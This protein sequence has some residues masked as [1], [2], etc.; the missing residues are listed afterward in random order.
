[1]FLLAGLGNPGTKYAAT[2]HN[3]GFMALDA[4]I[5]AHSMTEIGNKFHGVCWKGTIATHSVIALKPNTYMNKS[6]ISVGE[7]ARFYKISLQHIIILYDDLDLAKGKMRIKCGGGHGGHNGLR[8]IDRAIGT[9]YWRIRLGIGRPEHKSQVHNYVLSEFSE[10][11]GIIMDHLCNNIAAQLPY[12][13]N[14]EPEKM[15][16]HTA[17]KMNAIL[18][19]DSAS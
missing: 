8:D 2:R 17:R 6:G 11:G 3:A 9:D 1:M 15:M 18:A 4:C 7:A 10:D 5:K 12:L 16:T 13:L 14:D 19:P